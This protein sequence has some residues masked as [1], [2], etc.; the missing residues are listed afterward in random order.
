MRNLYGAGPLHL[1]ALIASLL[2]CGAALVGWFDDSGT[3]SEQILVW[4]VGAIIGHDLVLLPLY[5]LLDRIASG[6]GP[7]VNPVARAAVVAPARSPGWVYVRIPALLSGLIGLVFAPEILRLGNSTF[8]AAS[9]MTQDIYLSRFL[10]I[11]GVLFAG[12][13]VAYAVSARRAHRRSGYDP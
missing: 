3:G 13:A 4:F 1:L 8:R 6:G 5:S 12:S 9:G 7:P 10:L 2:I 11:C